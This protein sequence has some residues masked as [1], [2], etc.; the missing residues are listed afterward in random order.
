MRMRDVAAAQMWFK[1]FV[2]ASITPRW[3]IMYAC[4]FLYMCAFVC[5]GVH[6]CMSVI[7]EVMGCHLG[8]KDTIMDAETFNSNRSLG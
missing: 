3:G 2:A 4:V 5:L 1:Q 8:N 6:R 7:A